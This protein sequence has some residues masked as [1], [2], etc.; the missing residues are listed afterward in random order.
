MG[1]AVAKWWD[2]APIAATVIAFLGAIFFYRDAA[3]AWDRLADLHMAAD[4]D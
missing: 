2:G 4:I 1:M 3:K